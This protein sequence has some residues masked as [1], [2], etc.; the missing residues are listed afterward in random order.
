MQ[1][2]IT[3]ADLTR[4]AAITSLFSHVLALANSKEAS[5]P[6]NSEIDKVREYLSEARACINECEDLLEHASAAIEIGRAYEGLCGDSTLKDQA[7]ALQKA[8]LASQRV[9]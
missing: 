3:M 7:R 8:I 9:V 2:K 1:I 5:D 6:L 4:H